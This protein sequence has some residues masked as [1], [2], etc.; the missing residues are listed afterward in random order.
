MAKPSVILMGSKPGAVVALSI[1]L[2]R[3]W[4]V[5]AVVTTKRNLHPWIAGPTLGEFAAK[6]KVRVAAQDELSRD[7]AADFV[8]SYMYRNRVKP[9][10]LALAGRAAVN[11]HAAPLPE[12][13]GWAFYSVAILENSPEYGCTCHYMDEGF[14]TGPLLRARRF[15]IEAARE[16]AYSL[17]QKAQIEMVDLFREF[18]ELAESGEPLP[19][20]PQDPAK[21]RYMRREEFD[22]LKAIPAG[23]DADTIDR[24]ARAFWYPPYELA[25]V[26][27]GRIEVEVIPQ[28]VKEELAWQLH[29]GDLDR[30]RGGIPAPVSLGR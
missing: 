6:K 13:G 2:D 4:D 5:R 15:P 1:L 16:T 14:D 24:Y 8:I 30:L 12:F 19:S 7:A 28:I 25:R 10:S 27:I 11:F 17:E 23:A 3:G 9:E 29:A 20:T 18:C 22:A 26:R 21:M